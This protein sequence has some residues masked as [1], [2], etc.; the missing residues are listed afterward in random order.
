VQFL[1]TNA[2]LHVIIGVIENLEKLETDDRNNYISY[3]QQLAKICAGSHQ[4]VRVCGAV[5][6]E[7]EEWVNVNDSFPLDL[8]QDA[9][10]RAGA[11]VATAEFSALGGQSLQ[12]FLTWNDRDEDVAHLLA[13]TFLEKGEPPPKQMGNDSQWLAAMTLAFAKAPDKYDQFSNTLLDALEVS[14][15]ND[16][17]WGRINDPSW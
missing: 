16:P 9:A 10:R 17:Y 5:E 6:L 7:P 12:A 4:S 15:F 14:Y 8:M 13:R 1:K 11:Y 2:V 3:F